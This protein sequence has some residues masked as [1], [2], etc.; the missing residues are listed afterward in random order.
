MRF[1]DLYAFKFVNVLI[2]NWIYMQ[3]FYFFVVS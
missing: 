3:F 1:F 2:F